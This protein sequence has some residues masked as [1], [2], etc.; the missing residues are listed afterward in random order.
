MWIPSLFKLIWS[1]LPQEISDSDGIIIVAAQ[2]NL[3]TSWEW[4]S[5][6]LVHT[7]LVYHGLHNMQPMKRYAILFKPN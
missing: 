3:N 5:S 2:P 7:R 1:V 4:Q 6:W